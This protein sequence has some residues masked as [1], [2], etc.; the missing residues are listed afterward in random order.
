MI[1]YSPLSSNSIFYTKIYTTSTASTDSIKTTPSWISDLAYTQ[2]ASQLVKTDGSVDET[3][4]S[5][6]NDVSTTASEEQNLLVVQGQPRASK[7]VQQHVESSKAKRHPGSADDTP[8]AIEEPMTS[9]DMTVAAAAATTTATLEV[10]FRAFVQHWVSAFIT[11]PQSLKS[12]CNKE[13]PGQ[14]SVAAVV[15]YQLRYGHVDT[16]MGKLNLTVNVALIDNLRPYTHYW[17]Q[18]KYVY[19]DTSETEW[20][21]QQILD[22]S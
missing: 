5:S 14:S 18:L 4:F 17:Y 22:T 6:V 2:A 20:T 19:A 10:Q 16:E 9:P 1:G 15:G 3:E 21:S 13:A 12:S 7:L 11:W 8:K